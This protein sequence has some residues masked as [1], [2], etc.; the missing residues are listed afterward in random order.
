[1]SLALSTALLA[2]RRERRPERPEPRPRG[3]RP[4][5]RGRPSHSRH[6][7]TK[8]PWR[9]SASC[10]R[11]RCEGR[12][13][14]TTPPGEDSSGGHGWSDQKLIFQWRAWPLEA[15]G[16]SAGIRYDDRISDVAG[17]SHEPEFPDYLQVLWH[18]KAVIVL[19]ALCA[20]VASLVMS[21]EQIRAYAATSD[22]LLQPRIT[23]PLIGANTGLTESADDAPAFLETELQVL[24]SE[25]VGDNV[26]RRLGVNKPPPISAGVVGESRVLRV[27]AESSVPEEAAAIANAYVSAHIEFRRGQINED[28]E[29]ASA[30]LKPKIDEL[31]AQIDALNDR[32]GAA[33]APQQSTVEAALAPRRAALVTQHAELKQILDSLE[34]QAR[35]NNGGA[36]ILKSAVVPSSPVRPIPLRT[37][38]LAATVGLLY[39][40]GLAFLFER[41]DESIKS[42]ADLQKVVGERLPVLGVIP[43]VP[44]PRPEVVSLTR[45]SSAMAEAYR[46]LRTS[47]Q[48][49][50]LNRPLRCMQVTSPVTSEGKTTTVANLSVVL[51]QSGMWVVVVDCDLR[52]PSLHQL[53]ELDNT[54]GFTSV[55]QGDVPLSSAL[56]AIRGEENL[57][58]LASGPLPSNPADVLASPRTGEVITSLVGL[59]ATVLFDCPPILPVSDAII[60]SGLMDASLLVTSAGMSKKREIRRGVEL[61]RQVNAPLA[62]VVL[63]RVLEGKGYGYYGHT[64]Y[65]RDDEAPIVQEWIR[66]PAVPEA[67]PSQESGAGAGP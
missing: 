3:R 31:Q 36:R 48:V 20:L 60:L 18:R 15:K 13:R 38:V 33:P 43:A 37:G 51:A 23:D 7:C 56:Q 9:P 25:P 21:R 17:T 14:S 26:A 22:L 12:I 57:A 45:P 4:N 41:L 1:M 8:T 27:R 49:Y 39:G 30:E 54:I 24:Q 65:G 50:G 10:S 58:V 2:E 6:S 16:C 35:L 42:D 55:L 63:N 34:L 46:T 61:M 32:I 62:G 66:P 40:V 28:L 11:R 52:R 29:A 64:Y 19:A 44:Q 53:F 47:V 5:D 67:A 59:G